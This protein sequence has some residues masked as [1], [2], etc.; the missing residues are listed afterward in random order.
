MVVILFVQS[1]NTTDS[2]SGQKTKVSTRDRVNDL[3]NSIPAIDS[4]PPVRYE[5]CEAVQFE[6]LFSGFGWLL[7]YSSPWLGKEKAK[8]TQYRISHKPHTSD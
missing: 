1:T 3:P 5:F 6:R 8:E 7:F 2:G 4:A